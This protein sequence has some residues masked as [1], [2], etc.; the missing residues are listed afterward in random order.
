MNK[1]SLPN[2][3][4]IKYTQTPPNTIYWRDPK[5]SLSKA[6]LKKELVPITK[7]T[8]KTNGS[9]LT[10]RFNVVPTKLLPIN[11]LMF[12][13]KH[14]LIK[15]DMNLTPKINTQHIS[16][17][18]NPTDPNDAPT[19]I[20][21]DMTIYLK[22]IAYIHNRIMA[23]LPADKKT[24]LKD[25]LHNLQKKYISNKSKMTNNIINSILNE[26]YTEVKSTYEYYYSR[27]DKSF[28][29]MHEFEMGIISEDLSLIV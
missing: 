21:P 24:V 18:E 17:L 6:D 20:V 5:Y 16:F 23:H 26:Y 27:S 12:D 22:L 9:I 8:T 7:D 11:A 4:G 3:Q 13:P 28:N 29:P 2:P 10:D 19:A 15:H 14:R 1:L 25:A